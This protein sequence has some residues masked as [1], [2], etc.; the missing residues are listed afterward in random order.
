MGICA[1]C[2]R[3]L[4]K[5]NLGSFGDH[6]QK[7]TWSPL[8]S[9]VANTLG[10]N[11]TWS[12]QHDQLSY[13]HGPNMDLF[14]QQVVYSFGDIQ[15]RQFSEVHW[16]I[17][18]PNDLQC[19]K[20][21][22]RTKCVVLFTLSFWVTTGCYSEKDTVWTAGWPK[23]ASLWHRD[24]KYQWDVS[25]YKQCYFQVYIIFREVH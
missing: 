13:C 3:Y 12:M 17:M 5:V 23:L 20:S 21:S 15:T 4:I 24:Q 8:I 11:L 14:M 2:T 25:L 7:P 1:C 10:M 6:F 22:P 9:T 18:I 16:S 19:L